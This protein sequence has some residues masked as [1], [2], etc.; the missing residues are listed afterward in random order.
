M[1]RQTENKPKSKS[2]LEV[3]EYCKAHGLPAR[4]VGAWCWIRFDEKPSSEVRAGLKE[5]GFRW[6]NR[7]QQ[8]CHSFGKSS[9]PARNYRPWDRYETTMLED[10]VNAGLG[11]K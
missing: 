5:Q 9:R 10:Y 4:M 8:W 11:V 6:S 7:R 2:K 3:L 1:V